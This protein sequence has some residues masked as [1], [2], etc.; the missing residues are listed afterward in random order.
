MH[1]LASLP[2]RTERCLMV[3]L[4]NLGLVVRRKVDLF[5]KFVLSVGEGTRILELA[6]FELFPVLAHFGLELHLVLANEILAV[7][8]ALK[9]L[10][11]S[12]QGRLAEF[13]ELLG[14]TNLAVLRRGGAAVIFSVICGGI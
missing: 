5:A 1:E 12:F 7:L 2:I 3:L 11:R 8:V 9:L 13:T 10:F 14:R 4:T 6:L